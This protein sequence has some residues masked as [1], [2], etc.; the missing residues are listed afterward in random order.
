[1][2]LVEVMTDKEKQDFLELP[3]RLYKKE[4]C[5]IRP[6]DKDIENVFNQKKNKAFQEGECIRW[7]L[8]TD[9]GEVIGRV[10]AFLEKQKVSHGNNQPTG[11]MGFFECIE[12]KKAAFILFDACKK[13][14]QEKNIE[15]MDGPINFGERDRWWGLL[16]EGFD[17][18]PNYRCNYNF[19]YYK[20]FFEEYGFQIY[21]KQFTYARK[22]KDPL[23]PRLIEKAEQV[24]NDPNYIFK[25]IQK[26]KLQ[27]YTKD[28]LYIY[29][30]AWKNHLGVP[31]MNEQ[32][33]NNLM[34][35]IKPILDEKIM[36]FV[37]YQEEPIAFFMNLPEVNQIF[38]Y[39]NGKLNF[40][41]KLKFLYHRWNKT[42]KKMIG[43]IFGII[44]EHQGK[45]IDGALVLKTKHVFDY[46]YNRYSDYEMNWIG[47]FNPKMMRV[48]EQ[49]G[50]SISK[51]HITYRKLFDD[52]KP[53]K[54]ASII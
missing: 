46:E 25:H 51:T 49:I 47:D 11:G 13:W 1:M 7:I 43:V 29:N 8:K 34:N 32:Q 42:C 54:R 50:S 31:S 3:V 6:L 5:W 33:A 27:K 36:W 23:T 24:K 10:A 18:E 38:R 20:I 9:K 14:L 35:S 41:G 45:G 30:K 44:P 2:E 12:N 16:V 37:Y 28:F 39:V 15:A 40:I 19:P 21:F 53:F 48:A 26:K 52:T 22:I 17:K 4:K